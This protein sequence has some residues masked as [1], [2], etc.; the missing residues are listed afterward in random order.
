[1]SIDGFM[2]GNAAIDKIANEA[3]NHEE[4]REKLKAALA[5]DGV[6]ARQGTDYGATLLQQ[7]SAPAAS[8]LALPDGRIERIV[9]VGNDGLR[10]TAGS[11]EELDRLEASI[12]AQQR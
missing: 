1:M 11:A 8:D 10:L 7:P 6:I 9:Y 3:T 5:G 2:R 12:R 4:L